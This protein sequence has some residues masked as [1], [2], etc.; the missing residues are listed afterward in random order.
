MNNANLPKHK[1][2]HHVRCMKTTAP[3]ISPQWLSP[4]DCT[5]ITSFE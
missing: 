4:G 5:A 1:E 3:G 2:L